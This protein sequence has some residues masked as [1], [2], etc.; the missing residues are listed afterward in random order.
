MSVQKLQKYL[1]NIRDQLKFEK[2]SSHAKD[3]RIK[4][5]EELVIEVGYDPKN[6]K[7]AKELIKKKNAYIATLN[8][9]LKL[10][11]I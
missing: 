10:P 1:A 5:L 2:S 4:S 6:V 3:T 8:K 7:V 11:P 9:Q